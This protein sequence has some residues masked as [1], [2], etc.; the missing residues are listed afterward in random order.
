M[1]IIIKICFTHSSSSIKV[2]TLYSSKVLIHPSCKKCQLQNY[3]LSYVPRE[4]TAQTRIYT[5]FI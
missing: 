2:N 5:Q 3:D 1:Q 4:I